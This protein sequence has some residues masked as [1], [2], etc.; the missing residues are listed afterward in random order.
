MLIGIDTFCLPHGLAQGPK[1]Q[2]LVG[3]SGD[4]N[5]AFP[6][7]KQL[8]TIVINAS[9]GSL[10]R[11]FNQVGGSDEVW[12]NPG[13]NTYYLAA[14]SST[15]RRVVPQ[16]FL[17]RVQVEPPTP[18]SALST[19]DRTP[20]VRN[21]SRT[22]KLWRALIRWLRFFIPLKQ[23]TKDPVT[24]TLLTRSMCRY[25]SL[26]ALRPVAL[27]SLDVFRD[28]T[29]APAGKCHRGLYPIFSARLDRKWA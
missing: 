17:A 20:M 13:D 21:L 7:P 2:L 3:C 15:I 24:E 28:F 14:S 27:V 25:A 12:Y 11:L 1:Q 6:S 8:V 29:E 23:V 4:V 22:L 19:P 10:V 18:F 26:Q 9:D 16:V 5:A